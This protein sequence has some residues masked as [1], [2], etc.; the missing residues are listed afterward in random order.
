MT[1]FKQFRRRTL[2]KGMGAAI[3]ASLLP[4]GLDAAAADR[5]QTSIRPYAECL[6]R[7]EHRLN[8][9]PTKEYIDATLQVIKQAGIQA[10]W[11]SAVD[12]TGV[13]LFP[14][15][16]YP[17]SHP[18]AN[19][20]T[21]RY[22]IERAH[23]AGVTMMSWY[24]MNSSAAITDVH[25]N[26]RMRFL[27][28]PG[29]PNP[30]AAKN[31]ACFNSPYREAL[32]GFSKEIVG[33]LGFDGIWFDGSTFSNH[34]TSPMFQPACCCDFC[35]DR[36]RRDTGLEISTRVDFKS[37][38]FRRFLQ[39]RY[40][41]LMEVWQG[42]VE[43]ARE[44]NPQATVAFNNYRRRNSG[45]RM[46]WNTGIPLRRLDL[47][48]VMSCE[49]DGFYGQADIQMK[50]CRAM[51]GRKGLETWL[52]AADYAI[53]VPD[54][55]PLN[56]VQSALACLSAGGMLAVGV[57]QEKASYT[58]ELFRNLHST[59]QPRMPYLDGEPV[60]YAAT[61]I[62]QQSMDY[63]GQNNPADFWDGAHGVN[64]LMQHAHCL[65]EVVFD[66]H[67]ERG[68]I[69]QFPVLIT[70]NAS[71]MS[72]A[73]AGQLEEYARGGG[74]LIAN[75]QTGVLNELGYPH[76]RPVLDDLLGIRSREEGPERGSYEVLDPALKVN[77][78]GFLS[79]FAPRTK[80]T[81]VEGVEVF[82]RTHKWGVDRTLATWPGAW[83]RNVGKGKVVYFDSDLFPMYLRQPTR[84]MREFFAGLFTRLA[85]PPVTLSAPFFVTMNVRQPKPD[86]WLIHLHNYPGPGYRY[87]NPPQSR[88]LGPP[89]EVVPV[90]PITVEV[91]KLEVQSARSGMSGKEFEVQGGNR[92]VVPSLELHDVIILKLG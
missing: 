22:L 23:E 60:P 71:C 8:D 64:E 28:F 85:P 46:T 1:E 42:V 32:Y 50:I 87:P 31:S 88:Q 52:A 62:S 26:W 89:G 53:W 12:Y 56:Q 6:T 65:S 14:S 10:W 24:P 29:T 61:L 18:Q 68:D 40:N 48:A 2:L 70:G 13:P 47:D 49:L 91:Q 16:V 7:M 35:R 57:G 82:L 74:V 51:G 69:K 90:G 78:S 73:Q 30:E 17:K 58:T 83:I 11:F 25:P 37:R 77:E 21:F 9:P 36:F 66:D 80:A 86:E 4:M 79:V 44:A 67:V 45:L 33:R 84:S 38:T 81:P 59:L 27:E 75:Y 5:S 15:H 19:L 41:V 72:Q 76:S 55:E 3:G 20:E 92:I 34:A 54:V 63:N 39:W 43:A